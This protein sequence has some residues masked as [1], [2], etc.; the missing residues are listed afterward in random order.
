MP[1]FT[2]PILFGTDMIRCLSESCGIGS[3]NNVRYP[4]EVFAIVLHAV[5]FLDYARN[6]LLVEQ[7]SWY[8]SLSGI[9]DCFDIS[10]VLLTLF[11][12]GFKPGIVATKLNLD[13]FLLDEVT[14]VLQSSIVVH[15][16]GIFLHVYGKLGGCFLDS[17]MFFLKFSDLSVK[18]FEGCGLC[19]GFVVRSREGTDNFWIVIC[20]SLL[21]IRD[22]SVFMILPSMTA[23]SAFTL[24][25][26]ECVAF[27]K[28]LSSSNVRF[29]VLQTTRIVA[30]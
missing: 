18:S 22:K 27:V 12:Q 24:V 14:E 3:A 26:S 9:F 7:S 2:P 13:V 29:D 1:A 25:V 16:N 19:F 28:S 5:E 4:L 30:Y 21:I 23:F 6:T 11:F 20:L 15:C 10:F 17:A 8:S